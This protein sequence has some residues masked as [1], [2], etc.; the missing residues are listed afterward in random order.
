MSTTPLLSGGGSEDEDRE[1]AEGREEEE[2][3]EVKEEDSEE[4]RSEEKEAA[5]SVAGPTEISRAGAEAAEKRRD[6]SKEAAR[7]HTSGAWSSW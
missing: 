3:K 1:E 6:G 7:G 5:E 4:D 2:E